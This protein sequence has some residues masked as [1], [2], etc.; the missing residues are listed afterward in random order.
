LFTLR[1][2]RIRRYSTVFEEKV[3]GLSGHLRSRDVVGG[4]V[5]QPLDPG[6]EVVDVFIQSVG[7]ETIEDLGTE[8]VEVDVLPLTTENVVKFGIGFREGFPLDRRG[9]LTDSVYDT[10]FNKDIPPRNN[11]LD[12]A[13]SPHKKS[14]LRDSKSTR[15]AC[16]IS[17]PL[18]VDRGHLTIA[19]PTPCFIHYTLGRRPSYLFLM[20]CGAQCRS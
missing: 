8:D 11:G 19:V 7:L 5:L 15:E 10:G 12:I 4:E 18:R 3:I 20:A 1:P 9:F 17:Q 14:F 2:A 6:G 16:Y 13:F